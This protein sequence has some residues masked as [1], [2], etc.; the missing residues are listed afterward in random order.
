MTAHYLLATERVRDFLISRAR[1]LSLPHLADAAK[2]SRL[3]ASD[4]DPYEKHQHSP[5]NYLKCGAEKRRIHI[6]LSD[7]ANEQEFDC[8]N[9]NGNG[10]SS[11]KIWNQIWQ[12]VTDSSR[13]GHQSADDST[14]QRFAAA[15][16]A[17]VIRRCL[18]EPHRNSRSDAGGEADQ[19]SSMAVVRRKR[20]RK[21][22]REG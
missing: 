14:Q 21:N 3:R 1:W 12:R 9:H 8:H 7:P 13:G 11:S 17:A 15:G 18:R 22:R 2:P 6:A 10:R 4:P 16:Q 5:D 20:G 19:K